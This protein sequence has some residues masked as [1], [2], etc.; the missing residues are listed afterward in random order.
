MSVL[1]T[2]LSKLAVSQEG[3]NG[4]NWVLVCWYKLRKAKSYFNIFC[5]VMVKI[6]TGLLGG[7]LLWSFSFIIAKNNGF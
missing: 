1:T 5:V 7:G 6:G 4:I 2:G 3:V